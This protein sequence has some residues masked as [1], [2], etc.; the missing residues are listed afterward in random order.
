MKIL[1]K[2]V[3]KK[4]GIKITCIGHIEK[5]QGVYLKNFNLNKVKTFDHFKNNYSAL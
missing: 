3:Q 5:G 4:R 1:V 2:H